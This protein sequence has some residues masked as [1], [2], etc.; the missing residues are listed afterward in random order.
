M[1]YIIYI[2]LATIILSSCNLSKDIDINLPDYTPQPVVE[3]YLIPGE[4]Y[5]MLLTKSNSYFDPFNFDD[6]L[7][8]FESIVL[9]DATVMIIHEGDTIRLREEVRL[10]L[11]S[12]KL[13]N[14]VSDKIV[15]EEYGQPFELKIITPEGKNIYGITQIPPPVPI[16]SVQLEF[17]KDEARE[18][19]YM[20][21]DLSKENYYRR[22][23]TR[24]TLDSLPEQD[25]VTDDKIFTTAKQA[26]GTGYD[27]KL[28]DIAINTH[29]HITRDYYLF[30]N[31]IRNTSSNPFTQPGIVRSNVTGDA[32]PLGIFTG[33]TF[34][35]DTV[36]IIK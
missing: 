5:R 33:F 35:R 27:F 7:K 32:K 21:D 13:F 9:H 29:Y 10:D 31:S 12:R 17:D 4:P 3:C 8:Y 16:D 36:K 28:G 24:N 34:D 6:P 26:Y 18:L 11:A 19:I 2:F 23:I 25:Y 20:T 15:P 22:M 14:Y 30:A 1:R